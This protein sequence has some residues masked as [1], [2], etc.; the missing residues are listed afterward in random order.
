MSSGSPGPTFVLLLVLSVATGACTPRML[1]ADQLERRLSREISERL[2]VAN[3]AVEC[4]DDAEAR[5]GE[6]LVCVARAPGETQGLRIQVTQLD[7]DGNVA[8]EIA[9][10]AG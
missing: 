4:P 8:W 10:A 5:Q 7:D 6:T 2:S 1:D 9:G 3:V